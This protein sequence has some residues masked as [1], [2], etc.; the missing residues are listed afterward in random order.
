MLESDSHNHRISS[1][2]SDLT[3]VT[4]LRL[5]L[6]VVQETL[7]H[8]SFQQGRCPNAEALF[9]LV[10]RANDTLLELRAT[11]Q[12]V[13]KPTAAGPSTPNL[14]PTSASPKSGDDSNSKA[15]SEHGGGESSESTNFKVSRRA[16]RR[17]KQKI[18]GLVQQLRE[19][20]YNLTTALTALTA[21]KL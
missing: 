7:Q 8:P 2:H 11:E 21:S 6:S 10:R 9:S 15:N 1:T 20:R 16:W 14:D 4:D 19:T 5:V 3:Q 13:R 17:E 12:R 18:E